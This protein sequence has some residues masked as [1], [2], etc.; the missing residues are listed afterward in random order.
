MCACV[1]V[2]IQH[3]SPPVRVLSNFH[4]YNSEVHMASV[5]A[6]KITQVSVMPA[7]KTK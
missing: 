1:C 3:R 2:L 4:C 7:G 5:T 6:A